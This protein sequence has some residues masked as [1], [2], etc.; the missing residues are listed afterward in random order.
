MTTPEIPSIQGLQ[1]TLQ[2]KAPQQSTHS[3]VVS[4][5]CFALI[6]MQ[7]IAHAEELRPFEATYVW[8]WHGLTVASSTLRLERMG[9]LW[10]YRSTSEPR[11]IGRLYSER[12]TQQTTL[13]I[14][15]QGIRPL[16]YEADDGTSSSDRDAHV[17]FDWER[18]RA[19][20]V[21]G[22][23]TVDMP[24]QPGTQDDLS[25][26]IALMSDL[27]AGRVPTVFRLIDKNSAF[28]YRYSREGTATLDTL[29]GSEQTVI[30]RSQ[31]K[32]SE[33]L[34]R[35]W[36]APSRGYIPVLIESS[37]GT[38]IQWSMQIQSLTRQ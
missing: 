35:F 17:L 4:G 16:R 32:G 19:S 13:Q 20:G 37:K 3:W 24:L 18:G 10:T 6:M 38:D 33:R 7:A 23:V 34:T 25:I 31:K 1:G 8:R 12:P 27:I 36:C 22:G 28:E 2:M 14:S 15:E 29:I 5:F 21:Y 11:G 30:Y 9:S 26:Q